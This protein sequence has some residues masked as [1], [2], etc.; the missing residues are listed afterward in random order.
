MK[1]QEQFRQWMQG[2]EKQLYRIAFSYMKNPEDAM[3]CVQ[4][5]LLRAVEKSEGLKKPEYF[6]TWIVRVLINI[7]KDRLRGRRFHQSYDEGIRLICEEEDREEI[8]DLLRLLEQLPEEERELLHLRYFENKKIA[9][10]SVQM[11][12]K[13]GTVKSRLHRLLGRMKRSLQ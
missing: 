12:V 5:A 10:L 1:N 13:E 3:D 11:D 2:R 9:E 4:D 6:D 8:L 7:C